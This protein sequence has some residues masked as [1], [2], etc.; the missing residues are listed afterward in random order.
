[1]HQHHYLE[2]LLRPIEDDEI[3]IV[4]VIGKMKGLL[5]FFQS[6]KKYCNF[7]PFLKVYLHVTEAV[8]KE[9]LKNQNYYKDFKHTEIVDVRFAELY[10][11]PMKTYLLTGQKSMPWK[12][13]F[14]YCEKKDGIAFVQILLGINAHIN[15]DLLKIVLNYP[16]TFKEDFFIV[17]EILIETIPSMM[18]D[19]VKDHKDMYGIGG[20][21]FSPITRYEFNQT[22]VRWRKLVWDNA[23]AIKYASITDFKGGYMEQTEYLGIK[24]VEI[25]EKIQSFDHILTHI[26]KLNSLKVDLQSL[27][28]Q[29]QNTSSRKQ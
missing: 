13:Y 24:I 21:L 23:E 7:I 3:S 26:E 6:D 18:L 22:V 19:L 8:L 17:N 12:T 29:A 10:F 14:D 27:M 4:D 16:Y 15:A 20:L 25:F 11:Q 2:K 5:L 1:M 28:M 9:Y